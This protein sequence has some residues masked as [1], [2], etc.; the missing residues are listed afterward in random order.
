MTKKVLGSNQILE[1]VNEKLRASSALAEM[2]L[3]PRPG[4]PA[5]HETDQEGRNWNISFVGNAF[6]GLNEIV[7]IINS[8]RDEVDIKQP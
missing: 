6:E 8:V 1:L 2:G 4:M 7:E 5:W 3:S